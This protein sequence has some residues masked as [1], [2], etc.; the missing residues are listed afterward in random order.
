METVCLNIASA[1]KVNLQYVTKSQD[2]T[3]LNITIEDENDFDF[4]K[5]NGSPAITVTI[6]DDNK[7][8]LLYTSDAADE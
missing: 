3:N 2:G 7:N 6:P 5:Q 8:C 4:Y 1:A